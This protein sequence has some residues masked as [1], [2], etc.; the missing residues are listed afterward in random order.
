MRRTLENSNCP[1]FVV[2]G[3]VPGE[4]HR[5]VEIEKALQPLDRLKRVP[6]SQPRWTDSS[7]RAGEEDEAGILD[8]RIAAV[9]RTRPHARPQ[10]RVD[11]RLGKIN[12]LGLVQ[13]VAMERDHRLL[14]IV[15]FGK[16][17]GFGATTVKIIL[18]TLL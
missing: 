15:P 8:A 4:R 2:R 1:A 14:R 5:Q 12:P 16:P 11:R 10:R 3:A 6:G 7:D 9:A 13:R 17:R 18:P